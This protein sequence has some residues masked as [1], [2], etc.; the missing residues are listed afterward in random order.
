MSAKSSVLR[1]QTGKSYCLQLS[2]MGVQENRDII[3][4]DAQRKD[5]RQQT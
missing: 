1:S 4:E 3:L 2:N 5:K